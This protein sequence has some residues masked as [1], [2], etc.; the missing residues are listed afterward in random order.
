MTNKGPG[1]VNEKYGW[2][3]KGLKMAASEDQWTD[4]CSDRDAGQRESD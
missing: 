3:Q 2:A 1:D 4:W